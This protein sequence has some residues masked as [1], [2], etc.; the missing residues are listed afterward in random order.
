MTGRLSL[1]KILEDIL[2][3][4]N[5]YFQPPSNLR[6]K[7]PCIVYN[8]SKIK[9]IKADNRFYGRTNEY[10]LKYI[11]RPE[12]VDTPVITKILELPM[13]VHDR[14]YTSDNLY[15]DVFTLYF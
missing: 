9:T 11:H 13:C 15:H 7:Y 4:K 2:E 5:V 10:T 14:R 8:M 1:H 12:D 6:M 3:S